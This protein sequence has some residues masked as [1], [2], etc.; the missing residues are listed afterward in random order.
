MGTVEGVKSS[1]PVTPKQRE[2]LQYP[3]LEKQDVDPNIFICSTST[4]GQSVWLSGRFFSLESLAL[5]LQ[6][7]SKAEQPA[8][9]ANNKC[10]R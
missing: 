2:R 6:P 8:K 10:S 9:R 1:K 5:A 7:L 3:G 4:D